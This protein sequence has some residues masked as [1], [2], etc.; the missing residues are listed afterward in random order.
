MEEEHPPVFFFCPADP[1]A[2]TVL[3]GMEMGR[4]RLGHRP[5]EL[6]A[7]LLNACL[8]D[9]FQHCSSQKQKLTSH[10]SSLLQLTGVKS[11]SCNHNFLKKKKNG[12]KEGCEKYHS[13]GGFMD[14]GIKTNFG[15]SEWIRETVYTEMNPWKPRVLIFCIFS[16]GILKVHRTASFFYFS[17]QFGYH[18]C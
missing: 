11:F 17:F 16:Q 2:S 3:L 8:M 12:M 14:N 6:A 15:S 4:W 9:L 7:G 18:Y 5:K 10:V 1:S 13:V